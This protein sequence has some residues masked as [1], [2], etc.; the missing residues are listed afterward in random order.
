MTIHDIVVSCG[1]ITANTRIVICDCM[2]EVKWQHKFKKLTSDY[3][4]L[5]I[6]FFTVGVI[7]SSYK[8]AEIYFKFYV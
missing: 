5:K 8:G 6:K 1:S 2:G 3:E 4:N 7:Y